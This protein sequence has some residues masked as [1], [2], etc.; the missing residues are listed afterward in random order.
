[1]VKPRRKHQGYRMRKTKP[2]NGRLPGRYKGTRRRQ[3]PRVYI[4]I[5]CPG[6]GW[7]GE[8]NEIPLAEM[9]YLVHLKNVHYGIM[10]CAF[11]TNEIS[12]GLRCLPDFATLAAHVKSFHGSLTMENG[13]LVST[14]TEGFLPPHAIRVESP[15]RRDRWHDA[16]KNQNQLFNR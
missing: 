15:T 5:E 3:A 14:L 8:V 16:R 1:M 12:R 4:Q 6:C 11:C 10:E 2:T 13:H 9:E 7:Q